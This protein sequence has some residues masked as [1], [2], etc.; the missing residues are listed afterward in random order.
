MKTCSKCGISK[1]RNDFHAY[2]KSKDGLRGQCKE[3]RI[4]YSNK[5]RKE[6][7]AECRERERLYSLKNSKAR[8]KRVKEFYKNNPG[9]SKEYNDKY[10]SKE[11]VKIKNRNRAR[12]YMRNKRKKCHIERL[13]LVCRSRLHAALRG[14]GEK[15]TSRTF[16]TIGCQP[17]F[18]LA[19]ISDM[20][21]DGMSW[22][23]Y[24]EWHIDH[25]KPLSHAKNKEEVLRLSHYSN[26]QP[27]WATDNW[28]KGNRFTDD[29]TD[30]RATTK[31]H[32]AI[33]S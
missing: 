15:K 6:N 18:L 27:L 31:A 2:A 32:T 12:L 33:C 23:N 29:N 17:D 1:S 8:D 22:D 25:I 20:F 28:S 16:E 30:R 21:E 19:Y 5:Y 14:I 24:G 4:A 11:I 9:K 10:N 3:C 7:I 13:K 26:L